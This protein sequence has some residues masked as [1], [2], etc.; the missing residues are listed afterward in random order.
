VEAYVDARARLD[1]SGLPMGRVVDETAVRFDRAKD[2]LREWRQASA[3]ETSAVFARAE[4]VQR[5]SLAI[6]S[7]AALILVAL[8]IVA[9]F[10][11]RRIVIAPIL[12]LHRAI[13]GLREG[14]THVRAKERGAL[15]LA[16]VSH[17]LNELIDAVGRQRRGEL[18]FLASVAHDLRNPLSA[19]KMGVQIL[20]EGEER[21][22]QA[23][24]IAMLDRQM[25]RLAHMIEELFDAT[26]V[27]AGQIE[28]ERGPFDL[29]ET[30]HHAVQLYE[31]S[32]PTHEVVAH[33]PDA[34]VTIDGDM[35]R[36][37][38]VVNNLVSNAIK[39]SPGAAH[40]DIRVS[41]DADCAELSV[42]D[43]GIGIPPEEIPDLFMP[44]RRRAPD[45]APGAGLGLSVVRRIVTAHGG[46]IDVES[47]VGSGST[48]RVRIPLWK[49][50]NARE[51]RA[52]QT[53]APR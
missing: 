4:D 1:A 40:V 17:A 50:V 5:I 49:R 46:R 30:V 52:A 47:V 18:A 37:E 2:A 13:A 9:T 22:T 31:L 8:A 42:T 23:R 20:G 3:A 32:A 41:A 19:M 43:R 36:I 16:E 29:R 10:V 14:D 28:L 35:V 27:A 48:F 51:E 34:P 25:D 15:E 44:F 53:S 21:P 26:R 6:A 12:D 39:Y 7:A 45:V 11:I 33:L 24:T 38:Q